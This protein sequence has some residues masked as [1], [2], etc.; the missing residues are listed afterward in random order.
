MLSCPHAGSSSGMLAQCL[1]W[2]MNRAATVPSAGNGMAIALE[3]VVLKEGSVIG[4]RSNW[5]K[6]T[7][8]RALATDC[9]PGY[10]LATS[11][12]SESVDLRCTLT[13]MRTQLWLAIFYLQMMENTN[14][15]TMLA[16]GLDPG[17]H[18][19]KTYSKL[20]P[21][22]VRAGKHASISNLKWDIEVKAHICVDSLRFID[23]ML[24]KLHL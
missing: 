23:N 14:Y 20:I 18:P 8:S 2:H 1:Y 22:L 4:V 15:R 9:G 12:K 19:R 5:Q 21:Y 17:D 24:R 11:R 13:F 16:L 6:T 3:A 10:L 7:W